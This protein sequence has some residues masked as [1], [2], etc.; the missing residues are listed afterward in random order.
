MGNYQFVALFPILGLMIEIIV[1]RPYRE[2]LENY[3][4]VFNLF[5]MGCFIGL[6]TYVRYI[7]EEDLNHISTYVFV[8][9]LI[10]LMFIVL[11]VSFISTIKYWYLYKCILPVKNSHK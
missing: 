9:V 4:S 5:V 1:Y 10:I 2:R 6:S 8:V 7:P 11:V 3:R